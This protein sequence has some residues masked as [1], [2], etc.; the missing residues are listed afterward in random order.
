M[1]VSHRE[2]YDSNYIY[3]LFVSICDIYCSIHIIELVLLMMCLYK[4][5]I[6]ITVTFTHNHIHINTST[7]IYIHINTHAHTNIN[8][9]HTTNIIKLMISFLTNRYSINVSLLPTPEY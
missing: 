5:N 9:I 3:S 7:Y 8:K 6:L 2:Y 1:F 4:Y